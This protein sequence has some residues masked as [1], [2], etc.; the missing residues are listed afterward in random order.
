MFS[1][2]ECISFRQVYRLYLFSFVGIST[3]AIPGQLAKGM[4]VYGVI[5][6]LFGGG[7]A[8]LYLRY[9]KWAQDKMGTDLLEFLGRKSGMQKHI[10]RFLYLLMVICTIV[11]AS[12]V[13]SK[14]AKLIQKSLAVEENFI[15]ILAILL[16]VSGYAVVGGIESRARV[17]EIL[18]WFV[19]IPMFALLVISVKSINLIYYQ[20]LRPIEI[21]EIG[22]DVY[23][24]FLPFHI[25]FF[26][27]ILP[28]YT[29]MEQ[30]RLFKSIYFAILFA[31]GVLLTF[32]LILLGTFGERALAVMEF[33]AVTL[34]S[35]IQFSGGF[36]K[37]LD[38]IM[39]GIW[40]FT[41]YALMNMNVHYGSVFL[42][43]MLQKKGEKRYLVMI[44]GLVFLL[45][46]CME[47]FAWAKKLC[48]MGVLYLCG[49]VYL[50]LPMI[51]VC[52]GRRSL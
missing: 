52:M 44:L 19:L 18:F 51:L 50:L 48:M 26:V 9:L 30:K 31:I 14:F 17:Y 34:F 47:Y 12:F 35:N 27:L 5:S 13:A 41:L 10:A 21:G 32:Y 23:V 49:P 38:A 40:F 46:L 8:Y 45:V 15:V 43:E 39:M 3:L 16:C 25:L 20:F 6:I 24:C 29:R 22:K 1:K 2:N 33:P 11:T 37:R 4:G 42:K 7:L 28:R 36:L